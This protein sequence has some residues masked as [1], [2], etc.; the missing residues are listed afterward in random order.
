ME[1]TSREKDLA[2][3]ARHRGPSLVAVACV[4]VALFVIG[5]VAY[6]RGRPIAAFFVFGSA[7]PLGIFTATVVSRLQFLGRK[8]AGIQIALYGGFA[9]SIGLSLSGLA[10]WV[11]AQPG[12]T[13]S[14]AVARA[15]QALSFMAGGPGMV[16]PF[17]LLI[18][19]ISLVAGLQRFIPRWLM[20]FG[21]VVAVVAEL[22]SLVLVHPAAAILL[23]LARFSGAIWIICL[24]VLLPKSRDGKPRAMA[25]RPLDVV[26]E[27]GGT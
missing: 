18:A 13:D 25:P 2:D 4:H 16:V 5:V 9:A 19:G 26:V 22:S 14:V 20:T 23:P 17:G 11:L 12:V 10:Q 6:T 21:L 3:G 1:S 27:G 7:V 24:G 15:F 8:V